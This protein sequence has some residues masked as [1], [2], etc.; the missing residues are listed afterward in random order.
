MALETNRSLRDIATQFSVSK[1]ALHR[2]RQAHVPGQDSQPL[3]RIGASTVTRRNPR[4]WVYAKWVLI[5]GGL[6][7]LA[8]AG[9]SRKV[10]GRGVVS[11]GAA[12]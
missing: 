10:A 7:V 11:D 9:A 12:V 8:A 6:L 5:V 1:T 4:L 3:S 2:H